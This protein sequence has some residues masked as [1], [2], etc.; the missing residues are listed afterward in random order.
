VTITPA[1]TGDRDR[2]IAL[3]QAAGLTRPWNDPVADF[4][5]AIA[6]QMLAHLDGALVGSVMVGFD[7]HRGWV[8]YLASDPERRRQGIGRALMQAAEGWLKE[9]GAP[10]IQLMVRSENEQ[11][12]GFYLSLGYELQDV[13]TIGR[14][15][16]QAVLSRT[17]PIAASSS[18]VRQ[19]APAISNRRVAPRKTTHAKRQ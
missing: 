1:G 2:V 8:Y 13:V 19:A 17:K 14:R 7:G 11:A 12:R 18:R 3:W 9:Y 15:L 16:D 6:T 10:K 4:N 5:L